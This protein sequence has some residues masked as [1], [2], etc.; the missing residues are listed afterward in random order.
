MRRPARRIDRGRLLIAAD[1]T[2]Q[3]VLE[4]E[5]GAKQSNE[6]ATLLAMELS[7]SMPTPYLA[8]RVM[9]NSAATISPCRSKKR[10]AHLGHAL[11]DALSANLTE[12]ATDA[13]RSLRPSPA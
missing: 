2:T 6:Q 3:A 4:L 9:K 13:T 5:Y 8:V 11:P 7:R 12:S 10:R 1:L